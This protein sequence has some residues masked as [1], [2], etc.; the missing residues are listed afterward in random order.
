MKCWEGRLKGGLDFKTE[1]VGFL[2]EIKLASIKN[3][4]FCLFW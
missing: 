2:D 1:H 4:F 3:L